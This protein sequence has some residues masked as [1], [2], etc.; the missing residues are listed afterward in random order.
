MTITL[1][2]LETNLKLHIGRLKRV[3]FVEYF[4]NALQAIGWKRL[5]LLSTTFIN[6][7]VATFALEK[8]GFF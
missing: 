5:N 7:K 1:G 2:I 8:R 6:S 4:L 3:D